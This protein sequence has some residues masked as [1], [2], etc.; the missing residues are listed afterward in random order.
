MIYSY[1]G[2]LLSHRRNG[3]RI[4]AKTWIGSE[5]IMLSEKKKTVTK[6]HILYDSISMKCSE[7]VNP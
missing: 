7:Y 1:N 6:G 2:I 3:V 5:N 4:H